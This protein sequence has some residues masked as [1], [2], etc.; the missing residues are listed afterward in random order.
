MGDILFLAHRMPFPPDRG[1]KIR[2]HHLLKAL[3]ELAP[4]HVGCFGD[5]DGDFSHEHLLAS[6]AKSHCLLR[7]SKSMM[8]AGVEAVV[9]G[10]PVSLTAFHDPALGDWVA[11]VIR[12]RNIQTIF[13]FSGQMG[14]YI[15]ASFEGRVIVDLC[16]VDSAKFEAYAQTGSFPRK[17]IDAREGKL[18][19]HVEERLAQRA[20]C[21][22]F[23]SEAEEVLF[24]S[25]LKDPAGC[26]TAALRN[27]IDTQFF[28]PSGSEPHA[29]LA[30]SGG[31]NFVFTGQMDYAPNIAAALRVM[32]RLLPAIR[33]AH[34]DATFH[35]VGRAPVSEL[36]K[37]D[38]Q[39]GIRVWG[40]VPDVRPFLAA[41][42]IVIAPLEIARG[43]QNKV[44]EAMAM[45]RP[46]LLSPEAA[47]GIDAI[48][49]AHFAVAQSDQALIDRALAMLAD[50]PG[51]R[52]LAAAARR[53]VVS[54]QGWEAML[55]PLG[56]LC[57]YSPVQAPPSD[58]E[59]DAA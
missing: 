3:A 10:Q 41:A 5:T 49:G 19:S 43:V 18:L 55:A 13:V 48:D 9:S 2:S 34:P 36:T 14:Q 45:A 22:M 52:Q 23:V 30:S 17:W 21:T 16:D 54:H 38:G 53:Y 42:D 46:V 6:V 33:L 11:R 25:R 27:G 40:E 26:Q 32:D 24:R 8:R 37:R 44:L 1:D 12:Q 29:A 50:S 57:G 35:L 28:D 15:P 4:V 20:D 31:P 58:A 59:R 39:P 56:G 47:T 51:T 7:R